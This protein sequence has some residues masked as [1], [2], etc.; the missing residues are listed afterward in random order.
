MVLGAVLTKAEELRVAGEREMF[1]CNLNKKDFDPRDQPR[2]ESEYMS[3]GITFM[4]SFKV[5]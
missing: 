4:A 5:P 3:C 2:L 1:F